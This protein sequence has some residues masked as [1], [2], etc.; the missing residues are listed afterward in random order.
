MRVALDATPLH[1]SSGGL[2]RYTEQ[3]SLAL[4]AEFPGDVYTLVSDQPFVAPQGAGLNLRHGVAPRTRVETK[5]WMFGASTSMYRAHAQVFHGTNFEVPYLNLRPSVVTLHDLSPWRDPAW[6]HNAGRVRARTPWLLR[7]GIATMV[8]TPSAAVRQEAI[9]YFGLAPE[10][11]VA[12]PLGAAALENEVRT[13]GRAELGSFQ[14]PFFLYAGAL[15]PR[16][17]LTALLE[18]WRT[19]RDQFAVDLVLAGRRREDGPVF[20]NEPGLH[21]LGEVS[22]SELAALYRSAVAFVYPSHYEG[23]GLPVLEAMHCGSAVIVSRDPALRELAGDAALVATDAPEIAEAMQAL[24]TRPELLARHREK[25]L[26]RAGQFSWRETARRTHA[27]YGEAIA[28]F[29]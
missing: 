16:K 24:L 6:H 1:L 11:V 29:G 12:V 20:T 23:F 9:R 21:L 17:N 8:I 4:A 18:A 10:R 7:F 28:R 5:W 2:R 15:E 14:Q 13:P 22:D 19:V 27:V 25:S 26:F 3:L